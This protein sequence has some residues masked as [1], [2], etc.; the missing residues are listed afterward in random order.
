MSTVEI[1]IFDDNVLADVMTGMRQWLD[2][3]RCEP[4]TFRYRFASRGIRCQIDFV[5]AAAAAEFA[6]TFGGTVVGPVASAPV[7]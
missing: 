2:H 4:S 5:D 3:R 1:R 7:K 6:Q